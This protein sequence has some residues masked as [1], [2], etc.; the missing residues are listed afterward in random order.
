MFSLA[1]MCMVLL[2]TQNISGQNSYDWTERLTNP[3]FENNTTGWTVQTIV[4]GWQDMKIVTGSASDGNCHYNIW[5]Q[6]VSSIDIAQTLSLPAGS[7]TLTAQL[8]TN[9]S[10][11]SD[12]HIYVKSGT[13]TTSSTT[14]STV[15]TWTQLN[16]DFSLSTESVVTLGAASTGSGSGERGW[17]CIDNFRLAGNRPAGDNVDHTVE[18]VTEG[19]SLTGTGALHI[20]GTVPF[21]TTGSVDIVDTDHA[22]V[23]FDNLR[24]SQAAA[25]LG[26][27]F[28]NGEAAVAEQN[29]Q[30]RLYD[31]GTLLYPY[32]KESKEEGGFHPLRVYTGQYCTGT[33]CELFGT[34]N[35]KGFMNSLTEATLD[36]RIRSFRL[37]RGYMVTFSIQPEGRGYQRCFIA[38]QSDLIITTLPEI[39]DGRI[40]SYR[41]FRWDNIGKNGVANILNTTNLGKLNCTWTYAWG[42]GQSLGT[43]YECVPHMNSLW[44]ASDYELG[45]NDQSPYLKTDNEPANGNDPKPASVAQEL[46]RWPELMRTGR[47]LVSP[48]SYDGGEWWHKQ[49]LDSID[50]RGWRCD[51]VDIHC[52]W[53]ESGFNSI[54]SNWADKYHRPVW[55][56]EFIWGASWSGGFGIFGVATTNEQRGNPSDS[57]LQVNRDVLAR[58]WTKLNSYD[59]VERYAYWNDEWACS[60]ILWNGN[61]TPAGEYYAQM[62]TGVSYTGAYDFVP[63][64]WRMTSPDDLTADYKASSGTCTLTWTNHNGDLTETMSLQRRLANGTWQ[65]L[66]TWMRPDDYLME[67]DDMLKTTGTYEYRLVENTYK[68]T[69]LI[70]GIQTVYVTGAR[71]ISELQ[72]ME[73]ND[74]TF[75]NNNIRT[76][77]KDI[78]GSETSG[79]NEVTGWTIMENGDARAGGQ[80]AWG[81]SY[82]LGTSG[83]NAPTANSEGTTTGGALGLVSVWSGRA[84][85]VQCVYLEPGNYT[86]TIPV[87]NSVGGTANIVKNLFGFITE[88]GVECL[89]DVTTFEAGIW[90]TLQINFV[91]TQAA[92]GRLSAGYIADGKGSADMPHLFVDYIRIARTNIVE[93]PDYTSLDNL[94]NLK[95]DEGTFTEVGIRTYAKDISGSEVSGAQNVTGW[96]VE[97]NGDGRAAGQI[98]W[99]STS[100]LG[101]PGYQTIDNDSR[102]KTTGGALGIVGVWSQTVQYTQN[103]TLPAG[104]YTISIPVYNVGGMDAVSKNLFG[105]VANNGEEYLS[106]QTTFAIEDWTMLRVNLVLMETTT[107]KL[108]IGYTAANSGSDKMPH[109]FADYVMITCGDLQWPKFLTGDVTGDGKV[110]YADVTAIVN[111]IVNKPLPTY[112]QKEADINHDGK[113]S[114]SDVTALINRLTME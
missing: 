25:Y 56:T 66:S 75:V 82:F 1:L 6:N 67:Y 91:L 27:V 103:V 24:P 8:K 87:Y 84:Q 72:N 77:A 99:G 20:T 106:T 14:L 49:F 97:S 44:G 109:L 17:F 105:F 18:L 13:G 45:I 107:G 55:I 113:V 83:Y 96:T 62:K 7:Y 71:S 2:I 110:N 12:Q 92:Y 76:Y 38:D 51:I 11:L 50:A 102:E 78:S 43:D 95:F 5:A 108:S 74:G 15:D 21:T 19:I 31:H 69:T 41:I 61:L 60:K 22:V 85:Y 3:S 88:D 58:I 33:S 101:A 114:I 29:C 100:F 10:G 80:F 73:F 81:S 59:Y 48:S 94:Q 9:S 34:E 40:S 30:L 89:S 36:N 57:I 104:I 86:I 54:K 4:S 52:Y 98:A 90:T 46:E 35:T 26:S 112:N 79:L 39:L 64:D 63:T 68:G 42:V 53:N 16:V 65:T 70:S 32:G 23:F 47:R 93:Q 37:K 28:I 111:I